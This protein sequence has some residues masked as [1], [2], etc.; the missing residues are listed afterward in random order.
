MILPRQE[1]NPKVLTRKIYPT[2]VSKMPSTVPIS[3]NVFF[4]GTA[5]GEVAR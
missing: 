4:S 5:S 1:C 3:L 2:K